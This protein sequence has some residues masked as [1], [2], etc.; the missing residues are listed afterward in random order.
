M[1]GESMLTVTKRAK[2]RLVQARRQQTEDPNKAIRLIL[3]P[4]L[5]SPVAFILDE[6]EEGD[7]VVRD[8]YGDKV[9]LLG[10]SVGATLDDSLIDYCETQSGS[11]TFTLVKIGPVN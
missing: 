8:E 7:Q 2:A 9:L 4:S 1:E 5:F 6:Q 11:C 3:A 10:P